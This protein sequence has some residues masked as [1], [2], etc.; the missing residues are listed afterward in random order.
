MPSTD[1]GLIFFAGQ[2]RLTHAQV[3]ELPPVAAF[4]LSRPASIRRAGLALQDGTPD[5]LNSPFCS[6]LLRVEPAH[7]SRRPKRNKFAGLPTPPRKRA[8]AGRR[9]GPYTRS[10]NPV[11]KSRAPQADPGEV[12]EATPCPEF[13]A[14]KSTQRR[15]VFRGRAGP[16]TRARPPGRAPGPAKRLI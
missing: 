9:P 3:A 5:E 14:V 10:G 6:I 12:S 4:R 8:Y 15:S 13:R 1:S 2:Q 11:L 7:R 16:P